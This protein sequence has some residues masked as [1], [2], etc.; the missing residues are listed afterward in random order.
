M[1]VINY[2]KLVE[3]SVNSIL[4]IS[5]VKLV[6]DDVRRKFSS[7]AEERKK[8]IT[9]GDVRKWKIEG[10][11]R[12]LDPINDAKELLE[13]TDFSIV[14][15]AV[16]SVMHYCIKRSKGQHHEDFIKDTVSDY[17]CGVKEFQPYLERDSNFKVMEEH[18]G[19]REMGQF[20]LMGD[21]ELIP[22]ALGNDVTALRK[23]LLY[24]L[25]LI[26]H[27]LN[28]R[29]RFDKDNDQLPEYNENSYATDIHKLLVGTLKKF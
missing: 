5:A 28:Y 1:H 11:K 16:Q 4:L 27:G 20:W 2:A 6:W 22:K 14:V 29:G 15:H 9:G 3:I 26:N 18:I 7:R 12:Q 19:F 23:Y 24:Y 13:N 25:F 8:M 17:L 21:G 10:Y